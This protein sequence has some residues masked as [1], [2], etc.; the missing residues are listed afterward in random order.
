MRRFL[1]RVVQQL[2]FIP[3]GEPQS[4]SSSERAPLVR[5]SE[6]LTFRP[7]SPGHAGGSPGEGRCA[8]QRGAE[9]E[10]AGDTW[11]PS[12]PAGSGTLAFD[13]CFMTGWLSL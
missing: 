3:R 13:V 1:K 6:I 7:G 8:A 5:P 2:C 12:T 4:Q 10:L 11:A 9:R